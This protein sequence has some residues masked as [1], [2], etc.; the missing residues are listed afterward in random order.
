MPTPEKPCSRR[1]ETEACPLTPAYQVASNLAGMIS[2]TTVQL[3]DPL[4]VILRPTLCLLIQVHSYETTFN[5]WLFVILAF[6][7]RY[8]PRLISHFLEL[9][10]GWPSRRRNIDKGLT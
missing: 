6:V 5:A 2:T 4:I 8:C 10:R 9:P 3:T 7:G 1:W